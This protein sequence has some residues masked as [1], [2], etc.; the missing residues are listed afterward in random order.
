MVEILILVGII[1]G[2]RAVYLWLVRGKEDAKA[3]V[4]QSTNEVNKGMGCMVVVS[5]ILLAL[6]VLLIAALAS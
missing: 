6:F 1:I 3:F 4:E 5:L 2:I